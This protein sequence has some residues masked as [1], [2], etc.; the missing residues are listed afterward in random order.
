[1][2]PDSLIIDDQLQ[3]VVHCRPVVPASPSRPLLSLWLFLIRCNCAPPLILTA[4]H[5]SAPSA[6][7]H[8]QNLYVDMARD[9]VDPDMARDIIDPD[10]DVAGRKPALPIIQHILK[11][12]IAPEGTLAL[13]KSTVCLSVLMPSSS[14]ATN[15]QLVEL[16]VVDQDGPRDDPS[17]VELVSGM[18][19]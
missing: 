18:C 2:Q 11:S 4:P 3:S 10:P 8:H 1:M 12:M 15:A 5:A 13:Q 9:L 14:T 7:R 6:H 16:P 17:R 19:T